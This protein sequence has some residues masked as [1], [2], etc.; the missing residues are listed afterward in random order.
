M[1]FVD[2]VYLAVYNPRPTKNSLATHFWAAYPELLTHQLRNI[3]FNTQK[4]DD[5]VNTEKYRKCTLIKN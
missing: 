4:S 3:V 2:G 5:Q 1:F